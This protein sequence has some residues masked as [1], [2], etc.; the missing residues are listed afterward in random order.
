VLLSGPHG[1]LVEGV[2][3]GAVDIAGRWHP[4]GERSGRL[5]DRLEAVGGQPVE[6]DEGVVMGG[7]EL[8]PAPAG[9]GHHVVDEHDPLAPVV[10]GGQLTDHRQDGVRLP[11]VV[12]RDVR[13]VLD[14]TDHVVA[15]VADQTGMEGRQVGQHR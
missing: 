7:V 12:G 3:H 15:E 11:E 13:E 10:E 8:G 6:P 5:I 9:I 14:L 4:F 1:V 2:G